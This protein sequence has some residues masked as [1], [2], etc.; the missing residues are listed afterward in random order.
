MS[1]NQLEPIEP[2]PKALRNAFVA[3]L[4]DKG[5]A[6][7]AVSSARVTQYPADEV[8]AVN[9]FSLG[10][11]S[12]AKSHHASFDRG[13]RIVC[14]GTVVVPDGTQLAD[15]DKVLA[16]LVDDMEADI[17]SA[18][19]TWREL[20]ASIQRWEGMTVKKGGSGDGENLRGHVSIEFRFPVDE[21]YTF[22]EPLLDDGTLDEIRADVVVEDGAPITELRMPG[23]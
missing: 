12:Q 23:S 22:E 6:G 2:T 3:R 7:G 21:E 9:V 10:S 15:V 17:K 1:L 8:P 18:I 14:A 13:A 16:D 19:L 5:I 4:I 11:E 20:R